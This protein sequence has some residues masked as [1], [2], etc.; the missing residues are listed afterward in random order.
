MHV[1]QITI[2]K[3]LIDNLKMAEYFLIFGRMI[4][5]ICF[6][7]RIEVE[8][9]NLEQSFFLLRLLLDL[10]IRALIFASTT[11]LEA[12]LRFAAI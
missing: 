11:N 7:I 6:D 4:F 9:F 2:I 1:T 12:G 3:Y 8:Y 5:N 10:D